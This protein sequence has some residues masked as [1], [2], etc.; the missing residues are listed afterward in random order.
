MIT[1]YYNKDMESA[2]PQ[3][4]NDDLLKA[5]KKLIDN[6]HEELKRPWSFGEGSGVFNR[7]RSTEGKTNI[8]KL[9][10]N[11]SFAQR[12]YKMQDEIINTVVAIQVLRDELIIEDKVHNLKS[13]V[14]KDIEFENLSAPTVRA[15]TCF[16]NALGYFF[17]FPS[18]DNA[19]NT[20]EAINFT[21]L[22]NP[23]IGTV[24]ARLIQTDHFKL[25]LR[26]ND[27]LEKGYFGLPKV[28]TD[29][30]GSFTI[31]AAETPSATDLANASEQVLIG[32]HQGLSALLDTI[33]AEYGSTLGYAST[34]DLVV[35][36]E[37]E[38]GPWLRADNPAPAAPTLFKVFNLWSGTN[39]LE[40]PAYRLRR[41]HLYDQS[42]ERKHRSSDQQTRSFKLGTHAPSE[43][44]AEIKRAQEGE[45]VWTHTIEFKHVARREGYRR[46]RVEDVCLVLTFMSG[47]GVYG[48]GSARMY[49][50]KAK[51][52]ARYD[53][54][55]YNR[56][57]AETVK[58]LNAAR[59]PQAEFYRLILSKYRQALQ[60]ATIEGQLIRVWE[61]LDLIADFY[62]TK[63]KKDL[64]DSYKDHSE[65]TT[66]IKE[67]LK[68]LEPIVKAPLVGEDAYTPVLIQRS[69]GQ[70]V[71]DVTAQFDIA[72]F[73]GVEFK[74]L[75]KSIGNA[76]GMRSKLTHS[77]NQTASKASLH[78]LINTYFFI[79]ELVF[80]LIARIFDHPTD[81]NTMDKLKRSLGGFVADPNFYTNRSK[82]LKKQGKKMD[83]AF[84]ILAGKRPW[85]K[86][87]KVISF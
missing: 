60:P 77:A 54:F 84:E 33:K 12:L 36:N 73:L 26:V 39:A 50:H 5:T 85:P 71:R 37:T 75:K 64:P 44:A 66:K 51:G 74:S 11:A 78:E 58:Q 76:Y 72:D 2:A 9:L 17:D 62:C 45:H 86:G 34:D 35:K 63:D 41:N 30:V 40:T 19:Y 52:P 20:E 18:K 48:E 1:F 56:V 49:S 38:S 83:Q 6:I 31:K 15:V 61:I 67:A 4:A 59:K 22:R 69:I 81:T 10:R 57:F 68:E 8:S 24:V 43:V 47:Y 70:K 13:S 23:K 21:Y 16:L 80:L 28:A 82:Q 14:L 25:N 42:L 29:E 65:L 32:L 79:N 3:R 55:E 53:D 87:K 46:K 7:Y 27:E